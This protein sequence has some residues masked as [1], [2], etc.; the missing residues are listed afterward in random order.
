MRNVYLA[1]ILL[2][3]SATTF[4]QALYRVE[5]EEKEKNS[6]LIVEGK[7]VEQTS[8]WNV[9]HT[10]IFTSNKIKVYKTFKGNVEGD[11]M[12]I[13]TQGGTVSDVSVNASDL[14]ELNQ[15]EIG[16]FFCYPNVSNLRS[17]RTNAL[18]FDV[19]ASAQGFFR[20]DIGKNIADDPFNRF[21]SITDGLY[22]TLMTL[23]NQN[24]VVKDASLVIGGTANRTNASIS[25]ISPLTVNAGATLDPTNNVLTISGSG[26]GA[27]PGSST[28]LFDDANNG[29]GG[30]DYTVAGTGSDIV[31]WADN[32]I[33]VKV[34]SRAGTGSVGVNIGGSPTYSFDIL[35]VNYS[36]LQS[37]ISSVNK[38]TNLTNVNGTGGYTMMYSS[39]M[40]PE[41]TATF[42]RALKTWQEVS[43]L[44]V[45]NGSTTATASV[46]GDATCVVMLDNA[47]ANSGTPLSSGVLGVCYS[48]SGGCSSSYEYRKTEF[49]IV[50]RSSY[51][52]GSTSFAYG[53]CAPG[54]STIDLETVLLHELGH[55]LNL[56]HI[57]DGLQG[58]VP[59]ANPAKLMNYA[60]SNGV[61]R[62]S[63]DYSAYQGSLYT[64]SGVSGISYGPCTSVTNMTQLSRTV[65]A[66]DNC[67]ASF[68]SIATLPGTAV[69]FDIEHATSNKFEDPS[70]NGIL[71]SA[72]GT[73]ITNNL[74]YAIRTSGS[75]N[76]S[77]NVTNFNTSPADAAG[78]CTASNAYTVR[79][80]LFQVSSCLGGGNFPDAIAC[81][82]FTSNGA[83]TDFTGLTGHTNYLLYVDGKANAKATFTLTFNGTTLPLRIEKFAG[84]VKTEFN[85]LK[86]IIA[87][88]NDVSK[89]ELQR[90][91][92]GTEF[93][94]AY[95]HTQFEIGKEYA[96]NDYKPYAGKNYYRLAIHNKDGSVEYSNI[97]LLER[98]ER[99]KVNIYPNP[100]ISDIKISISTTEDMGKIDVKLYNSLGQLILTNSVKAKAGNTNIELPA[101]NLAR[102]TYRVVITDKTN[103]I[104]ASNT[105]QKL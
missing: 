74:Y 12:E 101:N 3:T 60:V 2:F 86:W 40:T 26:F 10:M 52:S 39:N 53:P 80:A 78:T 24:Y 36:I 20:Y 45:P 11:F 34:P 28:V 104:I 48:F 82:T 102:G 91:N 44:N 33:K 88:Y 96:F 31:S 43:G 69:N 85:L 18:L 66:K 76:L 19:Y 50:I 70:F 14:L 16:V 23:T 17:P 72:T 55:G 97:I 7:V 15:N 8:F 73:N 64:I 95:Q 87:A 99:I 67:P 62:T 71:C 54:S 57:N 89:L 75:G 105:L 22:P 21:N 1:I 5:N 98:K 92:N 68:P 41:A 81:R 49:D 29:T 38:Q 51:S 6:N 42:D 58:S 65:D 4:G 94:P 27:T 63:P 83:V 59:N 77:V 46:S 90:S 100:A 47:A 61:K 35:T 32:E 79:L 13:M 56:G 37:S 9:Q 84:E 103:S 30:T 93:T 25:S